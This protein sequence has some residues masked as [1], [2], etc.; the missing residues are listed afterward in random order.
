MVFIGTFQLEIFF[1][2]F[3]PTYVNKIMYAQKLDKDN[4]AWYKA[5]WILIP[6]RFCMFFSTRS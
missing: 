2:S 6:S 5:Y 1:E 3:L 4:C